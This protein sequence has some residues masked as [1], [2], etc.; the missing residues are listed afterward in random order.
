[1]KSRWLRYI[2]ISIFIISA[3]S[4]SVKSDDTSFIAELDSIDALILQGDTGSALKKLKKTEKKAFNVYSSLGI[5]RRYV[6]LG[7]NTEAERFVVSALKK[8]SSSI[9]LNAIYAHLLLRSNRNEEALSIS[10][11]LLDTRYASLYSEALL[12]KKYSENT[13]KTDYYSEDYIPVFDAAYNTSGNT[14]WLKNCALITIKGDKVKDAGKFQPDKIFTADDAY[15]WALIQYDCSNFL[16][17]TQNFE[18]AQNLLSVS[19]RKERDAI[20]AG[21]S[22]LKAD[23]LLNLGEYELAERERKYLLSLITETKNLEFLPVTYVNSAFW[24]AQRG[25][26]VTRYNLLFKSVQEFPDYIPGLAAYGNL[27]LEQNLPLKANF[28]ETALRNS[29]MKTLEMQKY[30]KVPKASTS[31][32]L[33]RMEK[34]LEKNPDALL[35]VI[36]KEFENKIYDISENKK[37]ADVWQIIEANSKDREYCPPVIIHYAVDT[38]LTVEQFREAEEIFIKYLAKRYSFNSDENPYIQI[39]DKKSELDGWECEYAAYFAM[40]RKF[41]EIARTLY[42]SLSDR[43]PEYSVEK[44]ADFSYSPAV[45]LAMIYSSTGRKKEAL[46]LYSIKAGSVYNNVRKAEI[47]YRIACIQNIQNKTGDAMKTLEYTVTLDPLNE[48]AHLLHLQLKGSK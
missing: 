39:L 48:K 29:G 24:A 1:M 15:F 28:Y 7:E 17:A 12:N 35:L 30:D 25:D 10:K 26:T 31:D 11:K 3:V 34:A 2:A 40:R 4:C 6:Q 22:A 44:T 13:G 16:E 33:F 38:F 43:R 36:K 47:L 27:A 14:A 19:L 21:I 46:D 42:E 8:D 37:V 18:L 5:L 45:N 23:S 20:M 32:A 9:E 41:I